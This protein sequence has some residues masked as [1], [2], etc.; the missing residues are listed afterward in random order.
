MSRT[1]RAIRADTSAIETINVAIIIVGINFPSYSLTY[2]L[3]ME[4]TNGGITGIITPRLIRERANNHEN[5]GT[6]GNTTG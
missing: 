4:S 5:W 2:I 6:E 3:I 1:Q